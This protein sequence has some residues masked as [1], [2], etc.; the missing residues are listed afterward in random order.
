MS[1]S[2]MF[3]LLTAII[4]QNTV[5]WLRIGKV[6]QELKDIKKYVLKINGG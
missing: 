2:V 4:A 1:D 6:E 3:G 5:L